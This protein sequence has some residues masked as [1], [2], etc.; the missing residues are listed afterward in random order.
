[1][2]YFF[3]RF[4][5]GVAILVIAS[6]CGGGGGSDDEMEYTISVRLLGEGS[7]SEASVTIS[8]GN[9]HSF[10]LS[11]DVGYEVGSVNGCGG[12]LNN[13]VYTTGQITSNCVVEV[14]FI[15]TPPASATS[16]QVMAEPVKKLVFTWVDSPEADHYILAERENDLSPYID[17]ATVDQG[18]GEYEMDVLLFQK[19]N[20]QYVLKSCKADSCTDSIALGVQDVLL[21]GVGFFKAS[22]AQSFDRFGLAIDLSG[23]GQTLVVGAIGEDSAASEVNGDELDNSSEWAGAAYVF[24]KLDNNW[25][26]VAYLKG[27]RA[28]VVSD[29][30]DSVSV[31]YSGNTVAIGVSRENG[32]SIGVNGDV[33]PGFASE[34]GAVYVFVEE[35]GVWLEQAYIKAS[36]AE[37]DDAF[38]YSVSLDS[39]GDHLAVG[40]YYESG[41]A[42]G[43]N[44]DQNNNSAT[45]AGAVYLFERNEGVWVQDAYI[46]AMNTE[47]ADFF[48]RSVK[49]SSD[50]RVLVVGADGEDS[51]AIGI[52][53]DG[54]NNSAVDSGSVYVFEY[55]GDSWNQEAYL[56]SSNT[57]SNDRFGRNVTMNASGTLIAV[58]ASLEDGG[59]SQINGNQA[60]ESKEDSGAVYLYR[61]AG[62]E[63][64][65]EAYIKASNSDS[66]DRFG[67]SLALSA[68]GNL[69]AIGA[70]LEK[71]AVIGFNGDET[72]NLSCD[73][74]AVYMFELDDGMWSQT[75]Y[76]K[77]AAT[78]CFE[79]YGA[80]IALDDDASILAV[81]AFGNESA[82]A[83]VSRV[84]EDLDAPV[85]GAVYV[86]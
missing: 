42:A 50:A 62:G 5:M 79:K 44:S 59:S 38:G 86:Y 57:G 10:N 69:L 41:G 53:G 11:P 20:A 66:A 13:T 7:V 48:G 47:R 81:G 23:D 46:K 64:A 55:H 51:G 77:S 74:G 9:N 39:S 1:M 34:S 35:N 25:Q 84:Q 68:D 33:M 61:K 78:N 18:V 65:F 85:A 22:N 19:L 58:S 32:S 75:H 28:D 82:S 54:A 24:R 67:S 40:A 4:Y 71:G 72:I 6:S 63:W 76:I 12:T 31:S 83:G 45:A 70:H 2:F 56:K 29:F 16:F 17:L 3:R 14:E 15:V 52:N 30:G 37:A 49:L 8:S 27:S 80:S 36:N 26:Q 43:V 73:T 21:N 60:D